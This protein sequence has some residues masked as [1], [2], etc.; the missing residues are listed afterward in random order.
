MNPM[1]NL[2]L[3]N[4]LLTI[5]RLHTQFDSEDQKL[6]YRRI[7]LICHEASLDNQGHLSNWKHII[8]QINSQTS[9]G[10]TKLRL[11]RSQFL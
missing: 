5:L 2:Q 1:R 4:E 11:P 8:G 10:R 7:V 6:I 9:I 3:P